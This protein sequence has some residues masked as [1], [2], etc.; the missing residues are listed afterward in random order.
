LQL[1]SSNA[2][3]GEI[4]AARLTRDT[5]RPTDARTA[6]L[7]AGP[8]AALRAIRAIMVLALI[9]FALAIVAAIAA[10]PLWHDYDVDERGI[11][12]FVL[13]GFTVWRIPFDSIEGI[14]L[15]DWRETL[16][17]AVALRLGNRIR[18]ENVLV[19][20]RSGL[21]RRIVLSP[22]DPTGFVNEVSKH[23]RRSAQ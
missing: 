7:A 16:R 18:R 1:V 19:E 10:M 4:T 22:R 15:F 8:D 20:R 17:W 9:L 6:Y 14:R 2:P 11:R 21:I 12:I 13:R 3:E 5:A 23:L